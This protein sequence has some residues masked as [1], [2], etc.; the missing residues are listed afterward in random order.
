MDLVSEIKSQELARDITKML[1]P[2]PLLDCLMLN[3]PT[4]KMKK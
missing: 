1:G 2:P 3:P 4:R